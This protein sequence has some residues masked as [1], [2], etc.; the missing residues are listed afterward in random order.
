MRARRGAIDFIGQ[1]DVGKNR[2]GT[3]FKFARFR[4]VDTDAEH[5][6]RKKIRSE[7]D[8]LES[9]LER[10]CK[11]LGE[12]RL[13]N[14]WNVFDEQVAAREKRDQG[15]LNRFFLA[16]NGA[17]DGVLQLRNDLRGGGRHWLKTRALPVTNE[18]GVGRLAQLVRALASHARG[19][20]F[21]SFVAHHSQFQFL[22]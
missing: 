12:G 15:K 17:G 19:Q 16:V 1:N 6:A 7:L 4:I 3:K 18:S 8:A 13:S 20:R 9:A 11:R 22:F 5:V 2:T 14:A 21:K 10:F